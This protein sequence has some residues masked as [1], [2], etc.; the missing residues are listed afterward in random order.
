MLE[1]GGAG[2]EP[3]VETLARD[4]DDPL[5]HTL[6]LSILMSGQ[7]LGETSDGGVLTGA[8]GAGHEQAEAEAEGDGEG[9]GDQ[10][11]DHDDG[12]HTSKITKG[13]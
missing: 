2:L 4:S 10:S 6:Y 9:Q 8:T 3:T 7:L 12:F 13:V 5:H 1:L 11:G